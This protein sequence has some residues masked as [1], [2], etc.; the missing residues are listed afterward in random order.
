MYHWAIRGQL[1]IASPGVGTF[2]NNLIFSGENTA[3]SKG[4][5]SH[6]DTMVVPPGRYQCWLGRNSI[7]QAIYYTSTCA[8]WHIHLAMR[9]LALAVQCIF[10]YEKK[11][12][13]TSITRAGSLSRSMSACMTGSVLC[14]IAA[15]GSAVYTAKLGRPADVFSSPDCDMHVHPRQ[16]ATPHLG[17]QQNTHI[18]NT[19]NGHLVSWN[20]SHCNLFAKLAW[21][22]ILLQTPRW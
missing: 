17:T 10:M 15:T 9:S 8:S 20:I 2:S 12:R 1:T 11:W 14:E 16:H 19:S 6:S 22:Q 13:L 5:L 4:S 18:F 7:E 21:V 3:C